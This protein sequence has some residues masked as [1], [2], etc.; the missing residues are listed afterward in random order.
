MLKT[1]MFPDD[2]PRIDGEFIYSKLKIYVCFRKYFQE[3]ILNMKDKYEL[4]AW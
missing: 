3:F 2:L 1:S 4:I